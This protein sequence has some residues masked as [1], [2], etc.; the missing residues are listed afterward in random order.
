MES[1]IGMTAAAHFALLHDAIEHYDLDTPL[2]FAED[3]VEGG[4]VYG[5]K[6]VVEVPEEAG[7]GA[8]INRDFLNHAEHITIK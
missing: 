1:R 2:M 7:L 4:I 5:E 3:P 6:G 8:F